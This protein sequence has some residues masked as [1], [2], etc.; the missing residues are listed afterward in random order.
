MSRAQGFASASLALTNTHILSKRV[1]VTLLD[2]HEVGNTLYSS[3][4]LHFRD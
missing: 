2:S 3:D 4:W 1:G